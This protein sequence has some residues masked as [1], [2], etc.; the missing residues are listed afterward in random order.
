MGTSRFAI[1]VILVCFAAGCEGSPG[2]SD[3]VVALQADLQA[4]RKAI[5]LYKADKGHYPYDLQALV[6]EDYLRSI[7]PD[8]ITRRA[9]TW[10]LIHEEL[11]PTA[12]LAETEIEARGLGVID[13]RSGAKGAS[14]DGVP[15]SEL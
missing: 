2:R 8:P 3:F 9:D 7:P 6:D 12:S 10:V 5:D 15:Y 13:V 14:L 1:P 4:I 11:D